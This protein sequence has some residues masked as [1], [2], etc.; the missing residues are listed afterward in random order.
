[1]AQGQGFVNITNGIGN[2]FG[3]VFGQ[4]GAADELAV[5]F[6]KNG[7]PV[8]VTPVPAAPATGSNSTLF[9]IIGIIAVIGII[10]LIKK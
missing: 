7:Q 6:N 10:F 2:V 1:M 4:N 3:S 9:I 8:A 5:I